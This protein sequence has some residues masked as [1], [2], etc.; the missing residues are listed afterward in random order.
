MVRIQISILCDLKCPLFQQ[1]KKIIRHE[2]KE[3]NV[4]HKKGRAVNRNSLKEV[5]YIQRTEEN[6]KKIW[7]SSNKEYEINK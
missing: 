1:K 3:K 6:K 4:T 7:Y 2:N 5:R